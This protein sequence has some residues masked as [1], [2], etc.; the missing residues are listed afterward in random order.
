MIVGLSVGWQAAVGVW[1]LA[2]AIRPVVWG[3]A[4]RGNRSELPMTAIL[5]LAYLVHLVAWRWL[6]VGWWPSDA[7][8]PVAWAA[9]AVGLA[10]LWTVNR[11]LPVLSR[12]MTP[13]RLS[14]LE[15]EP[16]E[17][18]GPTDSPAFES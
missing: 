15:A 18:A 6:T 8:A 7:T 16:K 10:V 9:F 5:L 13:S 2:L 3:V 17:N 14:E 11:T 1:L 4:R 12:P